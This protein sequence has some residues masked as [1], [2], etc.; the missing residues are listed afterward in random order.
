MANGTTSAGLKRKDQRT[1]GWSLQPP[2]KPGLYWR[3]GC[4]NKCFWRDETDL[5]LVHVINNFD[6]EMFKNWGPLICY[7]VD[8]LSTS[9]MREGHLYHVV[10][11][12]QRLIGQE[13]YELCL[14]SKLVPICSDEEAC[15]IAEACVNES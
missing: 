2:N 4:E 5:V 3:I 10:S 8:D 11:V 1:A 9:L 14:W 12:Y 13:G 6:P 15:E 7:S